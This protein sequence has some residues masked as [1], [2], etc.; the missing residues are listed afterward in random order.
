[1]YQLTR[2]IGGKIIRGKSD[3]VI[4]AANY[5]KTKYVHRRQVYFFSKKTSL[6][7]QYDAVKRAKPIAVV[8]PPRYRRLSF[9]HETT[10]IE[11]TDPYQAFWRL[12]LWNFR[13][14]PV[15]TIGITG[16]AGKSTTTAMVASILKRRYRL[17]KT[18]GN[19]NTVSFL[20]SYLCRLSPGDHVLLLEMGM[21]SRGNIARQCRVVRPKF[22]AITNVGEAH[23]GSLG[24]AENILK[25]KQELIDGMRDGGVV[26]L[27]ADNT[28]SRRLRTDHRKV[29]R[30]WFGVERPAHVQATH[31]RYTARGMSFRV[32]LNN[33]SY[34]FTIPTYGVHNV[35][36]ALT[37]IGLCYSMGLSI[38]DIQTGLATFKPPH[39]RQELIRGKNGTL[40]INDAW[41]ANPTAMKAGLRVLLDIAGRRKS[42]AVLGDMKELGSY[43]RQAHVEVG[44][45]IARYPVDQLVTVG[46]HAYTIAQQAIKKG[47]DKR[48]VF[49]YGTREAALRH[50]FRV[51]PGCVIYFKASRSLHFERIVKALRAT[52]TS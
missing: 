18:E 26:W 42:I 8:I 46:R 21:K 51:P 29:K 47:F 38:S 14:I 27:N 41:N 37:A 11:T 12:G 24:S 35:Y 31:I 36:N 17:V 4:R 34:T 43:T 5:G 6:T 40:L 32:N 9:P 45:H 19:L 22:G 30:Y 49:C 15:N 48:N 33:T 10:V 2:I 44:N 23:L 25:A 7:K 1:M 50:L 16:S 28:R 13:Q 39:M 52:K 20:P 3:S